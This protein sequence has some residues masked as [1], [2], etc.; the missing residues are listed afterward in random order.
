MLC[1]PPNH[2]FESQ[3]LIFES[4]CVTSVIRLK[5][6]YEI[7]VSTDTTLDGVNAGIWSGIE[8][9]VAI[10]CASLPS[11]KP[12]ISRMLPGLLSNPSTR[13]N[14]SNMNN[15]SENYNGTHALSN[16]NKNKSKNGSR[17][18]GADDLND[19]KIEQTIYQQREVRPSLEGSERSLVWKTDCY[20][21]EQKRKS[22]RETV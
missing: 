10:A 4:V 16:M 7:S 18:D 2:F 11:L 13:G 19:I 17:I 12:L 20:S 8:I 5:S 1:E 21:E 6:L 9:N 15:L 3:I 14:R 22:P